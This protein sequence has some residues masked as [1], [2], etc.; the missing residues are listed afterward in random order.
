MAAAPLASWVHANIQYSKVLEKVLPLER[1][2]I[3][4]QHSLEATQ[5]EMRR[6]TN[7]VNSVD[8]KVGNLRRVFESHAKAAADLQSELSKAIRALSVAEKL[9]SE[10]EG[11]HNR[12]GREVERRTPNVIMCQL[13]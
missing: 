9:I 1:E 6:L 2:Q 8:I 12:W 7:E 11:E 13:Q 5:A 10:L 3:D 4:L